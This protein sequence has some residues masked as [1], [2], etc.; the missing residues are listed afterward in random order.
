MTM[1]LPKR[2]RDHRAEAHR[3]EQT[4]LA[5]PRPDTLLR[6]AQAHKA[7]GDAAMARRL[8]MEVIE[9]CDVQPDSV[10]AWL[11]RDARGLVAAID[12]DQT[13][14]DPGNALGGH[15]VTVPTGPRRVVI[16]P[17][18]GASVVC[19]RPETAMDLLEGIVFADSVVTIRVGSSRDESLDRRAA[20]VAVACLRG[21]LFGEAG[22]RVLQALMADHREC[23]T[24]SVIESAAA[25]IAAA[26]G[27]NR[28]VVIGCEAL[29]VHGMERLIERAGVAEDIDAADTPGDIP[30]DAGYRL[31]VVRADGDARWAEVRCL[32]T[33][34][35]AQH[36]LV[37]LSGDRTPS[38]LADIL[39]VADG[40]IVGDETPEQIERILAFVLAGHVVLSDS[41]RRLLRGHHPARPQPVSSRTALTPRQEEVAALLVTGAPTKVIA[42]R[43]GI[44]EGTAKI[45]ITQLYRSLGVRGRAAF[46]AHWLTTGRG[47][48]A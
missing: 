2:T 15:I 14:V 16:T 28:V 48:A 6:A 4:Y 32:K 43:L 26:M 39:A 47:M 36:V 18:G 30:A 7:A 17:G 33:L 5:C 3:L 11:G 23:Q 19:R 29:A 12:G 42:H 27:K 34:G 41:A 24:M 38:T 8:A 44:A 37:V 1:N 35:A 10:P 31:A 21:D 20:E 13:G 45:H 40:V 25:G 9:M 22:L 46:V